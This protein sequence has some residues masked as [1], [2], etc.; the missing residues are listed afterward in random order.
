MPLNFV[1]IIER[2]QRQINVLEQRSPFANTGISVTGPRQF[3]ID[4]SMTIT[5]DLT[6]EGKI[7]NDALVSPVVPGVAREVASGFTLTAATLE[8]KAGTDLIVP[9]GCTRLLAVV[10]G[11]CYAV[12]TRTSGGADTTGT[13]AIYVSLKLGDGAATL[14]TPTGVSGSGGFATTTSTEAFSL[15]GLTPGTTLRLGVWCAS[16]YQNLTHPDNR[17]SYSASLI[18]LR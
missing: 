17:A 4:G 18:W 5:G 16:G 2:M 1:Q 8:E 13:D 10:A 9:A 15:S 11:R 7:H 6:A 14:A 12:N 3:E